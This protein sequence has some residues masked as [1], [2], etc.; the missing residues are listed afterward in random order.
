MVPEDGRLMATAI[1]PL[2]TMQ[3]RLRTSFDCR[4]ELLDGFD[5]D[6]RLLARSELAGIDRRLVVDRDLTSS[7]FG[8]VPT[9]GRS[10]NQQLVGNEAR[11]QCKIGR[12]HV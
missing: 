6:Q 7:N 10:M 9:R 3:T 8:D 12:A 5:S 4:R 1:V 11:L 2:G